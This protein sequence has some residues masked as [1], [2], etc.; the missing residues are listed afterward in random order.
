MVVA[1]RPGAFGIRLRVPTLREA[2]IV[3]V[4]VQVGEPGMAL[5]GCQLL[6]LTWTWGASGDNGVVTTADAGGGTIRLVDPGRL[7]DPTNAESTF[8][9]IGTVIRILLNGTIAFRGRIDAVQHDLEIATLGL[10]DAVAALAAVQFVET[11]VPAETTS[12]RITRILDL[13]AWPADRRDI[14]P[15]GRALQAGTVSADAWTEVLEATRNELG[16]LWLT[17]DGKVAFRDRT[18]AWTGGP[19]V[20]TFGC[21]PSDAFIGTMQM[22]GDQSDLVNILSAARRTGTQATVQDTTSLALYGRHTHVQ[23]DLELATDD[24]RDLW[25]NFYLVR[26][27]NPVAGIERFTMRPDTEAISALLT[28]PLGAIVRVYDEHHGPIIDRTNRWLGLKWS[29]APDHVEVEAVVGEDASIRQVERSLTIDLPSEWEAAQAY[30]PLT[31]VPP[32]PPDLTQNGSFELDMAGWELNPAG[33]NVAVVVDAAAAQ[34]PG[35]KV[36]KVTGS[37]IAAPGLRSL[38][39]SPPQMPVIP[40]M[41]Y[42]LRAF[43]KR[44]TGTAAGLQVLGHGRNDAS[45]GIALNAI[46]LTWNANTSG[47][48]AYME[49]WYTV[50][51][52]GTVTQLAINIALTGSPASTE[53]WEVDDITLVAGNTVY[54]GLGLAYALIPRTG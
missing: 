31:T 39:V 8:S 9:G 11:N 6:E 26:Q 21:P 29:V 10:V 34:Y 37:G 35:T 51:A 12:Q 41:T 45:S 27:A 7:F 3:T 28:L 19:P 16:A 24:E 50:P 44:I 46:V 40:G 54:A 20:M 25:S 32:N 52:D 15:A 22:R 38:L 4:E 18:T 1:E 2:G 48:G 30:R 14:G 5:D 13:A 49:G 23:N 47:A 43:G 33:S 42:R 36:V 17:P 53:V